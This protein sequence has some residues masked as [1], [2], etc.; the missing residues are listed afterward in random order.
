MPQNTQPC[1]C[2]Q[3]GAILFIALSYNHNQIGLYAIHKQ[4]KTIFVHCQ[5]PIADCK[6]FQCNE[7]TF[8]YNCQHVQIYMRSIIGIIERSL[9]SGGKLNNSI[10]SPH[11]A[12]TLLGIQGIF[13]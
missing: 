12:L 1:C 2:L 9:V 4:V 7:S 11:Y 8:L 5:P 6:N 13:F 10:Q 3:L